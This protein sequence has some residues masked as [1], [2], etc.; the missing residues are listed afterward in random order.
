MADLVAIQEAEDMTKSLAPSLSLTQNVG[1]R[2]LSASGMAI[3]FFKQ[4]VWSRQ[5]Q[6]QKGIVLGQSWN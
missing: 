1:D 5:T 3:D 2:R 4:L 6:F